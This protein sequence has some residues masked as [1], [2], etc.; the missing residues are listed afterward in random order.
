MGE[1]EGGRSGGRR[2]DEGVQGQA[3]KGVEG[4]QGGR[5]RGMKRRTTMEMKM[6]EKIKG[7]GTKEESD[8]SINK[9]GIQRRTR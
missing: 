3:A 1:E 8:R 4:T 2:K 5:G 6:K 9:M 7:K